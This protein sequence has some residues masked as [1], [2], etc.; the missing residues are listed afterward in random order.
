ML[1]NDRGSNGSGC[2]RGQVDAK[3][4]D[5]SGYACLG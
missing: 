5:T 1:S 2:R 3:V 4:G